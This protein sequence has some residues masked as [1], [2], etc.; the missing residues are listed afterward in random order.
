MGVS[1]EES[2]KKVI[3]GLVPKIQS[4]WIL[5]KV[6]SMTKRG[7]VILGLF[8]YYVILGL[9]P[10]IQAV[11]LWILATSASMTRR[12]NAILSGR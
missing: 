6:K 11:L 12:E 1:P 3:F 8:F 10:R 7:K 2:T 5:A 4:V 9:D